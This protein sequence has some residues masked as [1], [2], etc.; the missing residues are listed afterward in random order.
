MTKTIIIGAVE[1]ERKG[2]A[3]KFTHFLETNKQILKA[4]DECFTPN[5]FNYI[6]LIC[7]DYDEKFDLMFA[8]YHPSDRT[9][10]I[11]FLGQWNDGFVE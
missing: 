8:Y 2:K 11:L 1:N 4:T 3:I 7:K 6:E 5:T 10:G 9:E